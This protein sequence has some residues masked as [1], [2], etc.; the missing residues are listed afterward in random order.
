MCASDPPGVL[1]L[2]CLSLMS[3]S[4]WLGVSDS[5]GFRQV[6][7]YV[8]APPQNSRHPEHLPSAQLFEASLHR[9]QAPEGFLEP[10]GWHR[11][12][13][14]HPAGE[15]AT[16][17][18]PEAAH[19]AAYFRDMVPGISG[20]TELI[21]GSHRDGSKSPDASPGR[22]VAFDL[23]AQD[24]AVYDQ[25][26]YHRRGPFTARDK[27][28][29]RI[30]LNSGFIQNQRW[31]SEQR[32][33][34]ASMPAGLAQLWLRAAVEGDAEETMLLGGQYSPASIWAAIEEVRQTDPELQRLLDKAMAARRPTA[35]V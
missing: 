6:L 21:A 31:L 9:N 12:R 13:G 29:V 34:I 14:G 4:V 2:L 10:Q 33:A 18:F 35:K 3:R 26:C 1:H 16:Y 11:D 17:G 23:R 28:D 30:F 27:N 22:R 15:G 32:N 8:L 20:A 5:R 24:V 7:R 19:I 25:R